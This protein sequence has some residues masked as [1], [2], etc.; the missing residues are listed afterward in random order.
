MKLTLE[1]KSL[2]TLAKG[3]LSRKDLV[4]ITNRINH[5][6]HGWI[7]VCGTVT[8]D[9]A[10]V[11]QGYKWLMNLYRSPT[12]KI[13]KNNPF[14]EHQI[15]ALESFKTIELVGFH[16]VRYLFEVCVFYAP[17]YR[18]CPNSFDYYVQCGGLRL[19]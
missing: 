12:G 11:E 8:L 13:R 16:A 7:D 14:D 4:A 5:C 18:V 17:L 9:T 10:H 19:I 3:S 6:R 2:Q 15:Q 1:E